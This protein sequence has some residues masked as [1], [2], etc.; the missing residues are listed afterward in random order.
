MFV[1]APEKPL[2]ENYE[3]IVCSLSSV[4]VTVAQNLGFLV[5]PNFRYAQLSVVAQSSVC[6]NKLPVFF[7]SVNLCLM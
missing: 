4:C 7:C 3:R 6:E 2:I 1:Y 5:K